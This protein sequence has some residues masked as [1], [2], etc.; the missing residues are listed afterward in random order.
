MKRTAIA[1]TVTVLSGAL[2]AG[3][4][5]AASAADGSRSGGAEGV[6][7][8]F[9]SALD[10]AGAPNRPPVNTD[11]TVK[12]DTAYPHEIVGMSPPY[13]MQVTAP[14][15]GTVIPAGQ[16]FQLG[17]SVELD[18]GGRVDSDAGVSVVY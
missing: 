12:H 14:A 2:V 10:I 9:K 13:K 3:T 1:I 16:A 6:V 5:T 7:T 17:M 15:S 8:I 18:S 11:V 4:A